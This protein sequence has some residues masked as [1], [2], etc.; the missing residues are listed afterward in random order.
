[1]TTVDIKDLS[2]LSS[3]FKPGDVINLK[4]GTYS[5]L[6]VSIK[7]NGLNGKI[8]IIKAQN[9]GKVILTGTSTITISGTYT[10]LANLVLKNGGSTSSAVVLNG[11]FNRVTGFDA[12][13]SDSITDQMFKIDGKKCR[14]DHC[15]FHDWNKSGV[16]VVVSRPSKQ[17]DFAMIDHNVFMNRIATGADNGLECVRVGTSTDSLTTSKTIVMYNKFVNCN[18]EIEVVSNKSCDN[19]YYRNTFDSSEGTLTLRHGDRCTVYAN[20]FEQKKKPN[21]GGVRVTGES[22]VIAKNFFRDINGNGTTRAGISINNGVK[23]TPLNG[24]Y[25]VK[26]AQIKSNVFVNCSNDYAVGVQVKTECVLTPINSSI[27][28]TISYHSDNNECFSSDKTCLGSESMDYKNNIFYAKSLGKAPK[29]DGIILRNPEDFNFS[30]NET[31]LNSIYGSNEIVG[32][33][34]DQNPE[35]NQITSDLDQYYISL[36]N[37]ISDEI[38]LL[39]KGIPTPTPTPT[40]TPSPDT[41]TINKDLYNRLI[42]IEQQ[43]KNLVNQFQ[44]LKDLI[45]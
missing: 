12:S 8:I 11:S 26:N 35:D 2:S 17:E 32:P 27:T 15:I 21:S 9:P 39:D 24:Y 10:T 43:T 1:M 29:D 33:V 41:V 18:G 34:W 25:Q 4:D 19:I 23:N 42:K 45:D 40:P 36:K 16:W 31:T 30:L 3:G 7:S 22:H 5:N 44:T 13:Y 20:R 38:K 14:I 28:N 6:K 37:T